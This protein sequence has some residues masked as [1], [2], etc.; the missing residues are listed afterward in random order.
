M[1]RVLVISPSAVTQAGLANLIAEESEAGAEP[2]WQVV[3][4]TPSFAGAAS[5]TV[6]GWNMAPA[7]DCA[8]IS[9]SADG[10]PDLDRFLDTELPVVALLDDWN[11]IALPDLLQTGRVGL[12]PAQASGAEIVAALDAAVAGL[13]A[14]HPSVF[15]SLLTLNSALDRRDALEQPEAL[16]PRE[17]EV[18]TLLADGLSNKAIAR[19]LHLSEHTVKYHTSA[20]FA[21]LN[22]TSRTEA[23]IAGARAGLVLL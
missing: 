23:A 7:A 8:L 12:L 4:A 5:G 13:I 1:K 16:T 10:L 14:I 3:A 20:I 9:W 2:K 18:L 15:S 6:L 17:V 11:D 19:R 22:V 21:K